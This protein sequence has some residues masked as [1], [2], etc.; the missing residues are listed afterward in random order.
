MA[1]YAAYLAGQY[2]NLGER[3]LSITLSPSV[4]TLFPVSALY[5]GKRSRPC[6]H[7]S[8]GANPSLTWDLAAFTPASGAATYNISVRSGERRRLTSSGT[9][10]I[11]VYNPRTKKYLVAGGA[12]W[13]TTPTSCLSSAGSVDY[14]VESLTL[15]QAP[16][17]TLQIIVTNGTNVTDWPR[18]NAL[19]V[20]GHN[21]DPGMV[22]ELRSSTDGFSSN[23]V[24]EAT[25]SIRQPEFWMMAAATVG[26]RYVRLALTGTNSAIPWYTEVI[27]CF[28]EMATFGVGMEHEVGV[29]EASF[30]TDSE[31]GDEAEYLLSP[32]P[33]R[34]LKLRF[35]LDVAAE[36]VIR[37]EIVWRCRGKAYPLIFIPDLQDS[38][39]ACYFG[40]RDRSWRVV[41]TLTDVWDTDLTLAEG[42][43]AAPLA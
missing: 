1:N 3:A 9:T 40:K 16:T 14:Q 38:P 17:L 32:Q 20:H 24:L 23:N 2:H 27:P 11:Q 21:L 42:Y 30:S 4:D 10:S 19:I 18:W 37:E 13:Q 36:R 31:F 5:D 22:A 29:D 8:N 39:A 33:R 7:G 43:I 28:L 41:R 15:C 35:P 25:G 6:R 12:S 26:S 34:T